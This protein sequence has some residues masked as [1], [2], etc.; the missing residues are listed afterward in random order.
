MRCKYINLQDDIQVHSGSFT[1]RTKKS[2]PAMG[3]SI[4]ISLLPSLQAAIH[5]IIIYY[6]IQPA[7]NLYVHVFPLEILLTKVLRKSFKIRDAAVTGLELTF[8]QVIIFNEEIHRDKELVNEAA[9]IHFGTG[10]LRP[11]LP[12]PFS[13][14]IPHSE[15]HLPARFRRF[16]P[17]P[18]PS[19]HG[20]ADMRPDA[21]PYQSKDNKNSSVGT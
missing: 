2:P 7:K 11:F 6:I 9:R 14:N 16:R 12:P 8:C 18:Y 4:L 1:Y 10:T 13:R 5:L 19:V 21:T 17:V 15:N 20:I 3:R